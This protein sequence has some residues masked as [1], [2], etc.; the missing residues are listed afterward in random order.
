MYHSLCVL[1]GLF[2]VLLQC[3]DLLGDKA[4]GGHHDVML[5]QPERNKQASYV[6][7]TLTKD[8]CSS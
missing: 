6:K 4:V 1:A 7:V 3:R 5:G 8:S 2:C